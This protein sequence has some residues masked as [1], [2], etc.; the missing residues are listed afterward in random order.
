MRLPNWRGTDVWW[1]LIR[2]LDCEQPGAAPRQ[3]RHICAATQ[4]FLTMCDF[5]SHFFCLLNVL[6]TRNYKNARYTLEMSTGQGRMRAGPGPNYRAGPNDFLICYQSGPDLR[7]YKDPD[8]NFY[9]ITVLM[10]CIVKFYYKKS[11]TYKYS[12]NK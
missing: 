1:V 9:C 12:L 11:K 5:Q 6:Y 8:R 7:L 4:R 2:H 10:P 3:L